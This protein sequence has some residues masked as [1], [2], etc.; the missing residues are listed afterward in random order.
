[1]E[2]DHDARRAELAA[3][4]EAL[5]HRIVTA[6]EAAG[7]DPAGITVIAVTKTFP[8]ADA[9]L[10]VDLGLH[11]LGESKDQEA[12]AKADALAG[13]PVRWHFV[14]RLQTNK[15][16]SVAGYATA[17]HS[18]DRRELVASLDRATERADRAE[19][20]EVFVQ[21]SLDGDPSRGGAVEGDLPALADAVA[22]SPR[23]RLRGIMAVPPMDVDPDTAFARVAEVSARFAAAHPDARAVSAGMSD[24]LDAAVR[25]G[26]TH[27][28]IGTALL[29]RRNTQFS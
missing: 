25:H 1:M 7:R 12:R 8:A 4:L 13:L 26:S 20:L 21:L 23:L 2:E 17:I 18:V 14:G 3:S 10:L 24:D 22:A 11:D 28:R 9:A 29:G 19:P 5:R 6:A 16:R 27:V 15:A